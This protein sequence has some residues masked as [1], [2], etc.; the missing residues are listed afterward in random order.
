MF[1]SVY[2]WLLDNWQLIV[3]DVVLGALI[4][5]VPF[6]VIRRYRGR[7]PQFSF[8][9]FNLGNLLRWRPR[10]DH[11]QLALVPF[12][13]AAWG[14]GL[15]FLAGI[16]PWL[17][18][19]IQLMEGFYVSIFLFPPIPGAVNSLIQQPNRYRPAPA[20]I[21][22]TEDSEI[23]T[24]DYPP[25]K[26]GFFVKLVP[27][28]EIRIELGGIAVKGMMATD[29]R[30]YLGEQANDYTRKH[31]EYWENVPTPPGYEDSH[32]IPAPWKKRT[33]KWLIYSPFSIV[34]WLWKLYVYKLTGAV[35][36]GIYPFQMPR[37]VP[38]E[39]FVMRVKNGNAV[40]DR[41]EDYSNHYRVEQ[42]MF[43]L[44]IGDV[45]T[46]DMIP[47]KI[48]LNV[49]ASVFNSYLTAYRTDDRWSSRLIASITDPVTAYARS[50]SLR[51]LWVAASEAVARTLAERVMALGRR[52]L[53]PV[54]LDQLDPRSP[55]VYGIQ[56][57]SVE[58]I[59]ISPMN[60]TDTLAFGAEARAEVQKRAL[61]QLAEGNAAELTETGKAMAA[62]D[63]AITNN[64]AALEIA[65]LQ[66]RIRTAQAAADGKGNNLIIVD[67]GSIN[68]DQALMAQ[69]L[70]RLG[71][72]NRR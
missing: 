13:T 57:H 69:L 47:L 59:D 61:K 42:F 32:P 4:F 20:D 34:W 45:D 17:W 21:G 63:V 56:I 35:F 10:R 46:Q 29:H 62:M 44:L 19:P 39:R 58:I 1:T 27:G 2:T 24:R 18:I 51:T 50:T 68:Q 22:K 14:I 23:T 71:N 16:V 53:P 36:T 30:M 67:G 37:V 25:S 12:I 38:M 26:F 66:A 72:E 65:R 9:S 3:L 60:D 52:Q 55:C 11:M 54:P 43:P 6:F 15:Y 40:V 41:I 7:W 33:W 48:L 28:R 64:P 70:R 8:P 31:A 49:V 5:F